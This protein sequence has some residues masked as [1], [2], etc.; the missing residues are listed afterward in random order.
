M[1][2]EQDLKKL[3]KLSLEDKIIRVEEL[4]NG[5]E[6]P[7]P[8]ELGILL[9]L[10]M[11]AEIQHGKALGSETA[12]MVADWAKKYPADFVDKAVADAKDFL[13]NAS[14][15]TNKLHESLSVQEEKK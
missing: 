11:G 14:K 13:L 10:K 5:K 2:S 4:L 8:V 15:L 9:A 1:I 6:K 12:E 3:E 7:R